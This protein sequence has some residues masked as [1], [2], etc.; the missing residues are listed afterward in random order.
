M[1][2]TGTESI[3]TTWIDERDTAFFRITA[4]LFPGEFTYGA[5]VLLASYD[6]GCLADA[7]SS[8]TLPSAGATTAAATT[9]VTVR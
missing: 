8:T 1:A 7:A 3:P 5:G 9:P 6:D 4:S 2:T